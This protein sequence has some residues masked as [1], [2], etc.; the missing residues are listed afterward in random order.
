[1]FG[2]IMAV[3]VAVIVLL[4]SVL[5]GL[6]LYT[7]T[8]RQTAIRQ[9]NLRAE[10]RE[11]AYLA[12][13]YSGGS[14]TYTLGTSLFSGSAQNTVALKH[15]RW[16]AAQV[17]D[18]YGAYIA[19]VDRSG[20]VMDNMAVTYEKNPDFAKT[21]NGKDIYEA[22]LTIIGGDEISIRRQVDGDWYFT[23]GVPFVSGGLVRG[24]VFIQTPAQEIEV[25]AGTLL[26]PVLGVVLG[27]C[28]LA[29]GALLLYLRRI[30]HP[31]SVLSGAAKAMS[32]GNFSV[33]APE[34]KATCPEIAELSASFNTMAEKLSQLEESRRE[35]VA[36]VSHE[37]RS[38]ITAISGYVEGMRDGT[39]GQEDYPQYLTIV[40][41][42]TTRL[43]NLIGDL[44]KLSRL[45][46][47]DAALNKTNFD[48]CEAA[49]QALLCFEQRINQ[50][51]L[52]VEI[53][54]P[55][56]GLT[57]HAAQDS[58]T[59]VL[60]NLIDNA[61]KFVNEG[62]TLSV[63]I[64][65]HGNSAMISVG[66]TGK[67]I[68]PEELPLVFDRFHKIDKSRSNDRDGWG[69]GL[70]IVKTIVLAHGED[71]YVTSQDGKTEFT[72]SMSLAK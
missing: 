38:P 42:E 35:F 62:G 45:E 46:K 52:N 24:A 49:G 37:L 59:Q 15:L 19:I 64:R 7:L 68:P 70:Y 67:T 11:I 41:D 60:Y 58:V 30:L 40:S 51:K 44:L 13:L 22:L 18:E 23:V 8:S 10:A 26:L 3:V 33:R 31:V 69:L 21:L 20:Q 32:E 50:K 27:F 65:R 39:I 43:K 56:E 16:K 12:S 2:R 34:G 47:D 53:D 9:E 1:M 4:T 63:R 36:N 57:I 66:N 61:V 54:M 55:D 14:S 17:Y 25:R 48:I 29:G 72:F 6:G 5:S 71:V 28:I